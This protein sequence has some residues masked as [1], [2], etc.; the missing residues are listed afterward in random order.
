MTNQEALK[1][2]NHCATMSCARWNKSRWNPKT[3]LG[4]SIKTKL[5]DKIYQFSR[6]CYRRKYWEMSETAWEFGGQRIWIGILQKN[7]RI[8]LNSYPWPYSSPQFARWT[9]NADPEDC[10]LVFDPSGFVIRHCMSYCAWKIREITGKWPKCEVAAWIQPKNWLY[11]LEVLGY[12]EVDIT[13]Q[14]GYRYVGIDPFYGEHGMV[15]WYEGKTVKNGAM[16]STYRNKSFDSWIIRE[17]DTSNNIWI[18][19]D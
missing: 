12:K 1:L 2:A 11:Y 19:I 5:I 17:E 16:V 7:R 14:P 13:P 18:R 10:S 3:S 8:P 15:F 4:K 9:E 6:W